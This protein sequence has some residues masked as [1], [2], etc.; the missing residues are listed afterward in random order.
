MGLT[1]PR[2]KYHEELPKYVSGNSWFFSKPFISFRNKFPMFA[3]SDAR[4]YS[5]SKVPYLEQEKRDNWP[6]NLLKQRDVILL[7]VP[8]PA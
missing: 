4:D 2:H 8:A 3:L 6:I 5:F 1:R 7:H